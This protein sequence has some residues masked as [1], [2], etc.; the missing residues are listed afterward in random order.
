MDCRFLKDL[1]YFLMKI[2]IINN[3]THDI[4][5]IIWILN[6]HELKIF[7][8]DEDYDTEC[9]LFVLT[10]WSNYSIFHRPNPYKKEINL[11][12]KHKK[13]IIWICL[14]AQ[15]IAKSFWS[16]FGKLSRKVRRVINIKFI[17]LNK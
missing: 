10:W 16:S 12:K 13:P 4:S 15:L 3:E 8:Y 1:Q 2:C 9:D 17:S 14:G 5:K 7:R 6:E 11:I